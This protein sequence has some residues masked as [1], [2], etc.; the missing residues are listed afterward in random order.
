M[1]DGFL[2]EGILRIAREK[3]LVEVDLVNFRDFS[4]DPHRK[5]DD[6]PYGGGPGMVL[7]P[8]PIFS[9]LDHLEKIRGGPG[10]R[11]LLSPQGE[12]F[13]QRLAREFS[14]ESHMVLVC[15]RYEGVDDRVCLGANAREV[16]VGDYVL[17]GGEI[18]AMALIES[19]AR[20]V[21][22]VVGAEA[23]L[24]EES[25][26]DGLLEYPQYTRPEVFRG[27]AVPEVLRSGD[28]GAIRAW[29]LSEALRR[30]RER[31]PDLLEGRPPEP[32]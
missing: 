4:D 27:M 31:R 8:G 7:A 26:T 5:V 16:S 14:R 13:N 19:V 1:F 20:L 11:V 9:A 24:S 15:G 32:S 17:S 22:G 25:F 12:R 3:G 21:P 30:T 23:S 28:H 18:P 29:R 2:R 10:R 6:R